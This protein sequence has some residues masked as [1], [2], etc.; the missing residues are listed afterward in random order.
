M[1]KPFSPYKFE[2]QTS[3]KRYTIFKNIYNIHTLRERGVNVVIWN[4]GEG[5]IS[6]DC[7]FTYQFGTLRQSAV[8]I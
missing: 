4:G 1:V 3:A 6:Y 8:V 2:T 5:I 7:P